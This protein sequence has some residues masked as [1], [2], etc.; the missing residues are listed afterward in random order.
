MVVK[1]KD[2]R[3][4]A[5]VMTSL[6]ACEAPPSLIILWPTPAVSHT[7]AHVMNDDEQ[8]VLTRP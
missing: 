4:W 3:L 6:K 2:A 8:V 5:W 7:L 1:D